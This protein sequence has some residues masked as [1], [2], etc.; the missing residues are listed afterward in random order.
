MKKE[1]GQVDRDLAFCAQSWPQTVTW[2][3]ALF[4]VRAWRWGDFLVLRT[5]P[6][7][8]SSDQ[9]RHDHDRF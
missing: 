4:P 1:K 3:A 5:S 2:A 7:S 9:H 6:E 8:Q